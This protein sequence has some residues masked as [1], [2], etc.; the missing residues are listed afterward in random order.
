MPSAATSNS[1]QYQRDN[2]AAMNVHACAFAKITTQ[3]IINTGI[4]MS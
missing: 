1:Y 4:Q 3:Q 2:I